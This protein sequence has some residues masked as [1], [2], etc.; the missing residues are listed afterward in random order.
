MIVCECDIAVIG[1]AGAA[2]GRRN[3]QTA[4]VELKLREARRPQGFFSLAFFLSSA[5]TFASCR[6]AASIA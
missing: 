4:M 2:A 6:S 5:K 3:I 1:V